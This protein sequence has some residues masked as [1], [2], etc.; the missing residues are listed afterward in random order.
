MLKLTLKC[1]LKCSYMFRS[2]KPSSGSLLLCF[3]KVII[4]KIVNNVMNRFGC[5]AA[6]LFNSCSCVYSAQWDCVYSA[7]C[8]V[9][10]CVQFTVQ[11]GT[12]CTVHSETVYSPDCD[13]VYSAQYRVGLCVQCTVQSGTVFTVYSAVQDCVYS[14]QCHTS[15]RTG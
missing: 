11:S 2:N 4:I 14:V 7:Q 13:C 15:I 5:V 10:L 9:G 8:R 6:Y 12:V 1:T 3:V